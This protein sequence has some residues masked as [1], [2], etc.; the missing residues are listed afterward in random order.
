MRVRA[1]AL[2]FYDGQ[3]REPGEEF[4]IPDGLPGDWYVE[5]E[6]QDAQGDTPPPVKKKPNN[7]RGG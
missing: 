3:L 6:D 4:D 7:A 1:V 2:G 5:V